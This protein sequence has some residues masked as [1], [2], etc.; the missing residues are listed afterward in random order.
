MNLDEFGILYILGGNRRPPVYYRR[1]CQVRAYTK[2]NYNGILLRIR[3]H[4]R[5][6]HFCK[7]PHRT[8]PEIRQYK[9]LSAFFPRTSQLEIDATYRYYR[10]KT[11]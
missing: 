2:R 7:N 4:R 1:G 9:P 5:M 10:Q 3:S 11:Q 8:K 6:A